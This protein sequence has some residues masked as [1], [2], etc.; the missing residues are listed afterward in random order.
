MKLRE[1]ERITWEGKRRS[2]I[3]DLGVH[4]RPVQERIPISIA[5]V[6]APES[7]FRTGVLRL[8]IALAIIGGLPE[9][10]APFAECIATRRARRG[11]TRCRRSASTR[12]VTWRRPPWR[13][14]ESFPPV[15]AT[16]NRI[17]SE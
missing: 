2:P 15:A 17:G 8:P 4:P 9:R 1:S 5:V 3:Q 10:F 6:G 14:D 16:M 7:A 12:T 13:L 11:T